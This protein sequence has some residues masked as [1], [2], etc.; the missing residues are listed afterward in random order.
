MTRGGETLRRASVF[1][2]LGAWLHIWVPPRDVEVPPVPWRK[3]AVGTG[4]AV[5]VLG[6][7]L[8]LLVPRIDHGKAT[9]AAADRRSTAAAQARN[10]ARVAREQAAHHGSAVALRP[11]AGA[12]AQERDAARARLVAGLEAD[13]LADARARSARGEMRQVEGPATCRPG[14]GQ[15]AGVMNCFVVATHIKKTSRTTAGVIGYPFRAVIDYKRF[16][17]NWCKV[18]GIPGEMSIPDPRQL[19][20]LPQAC[21]APGSL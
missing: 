17:Y 12:S 19:V 3:L 13:V 8:A 21:K 14:A 1:E 18:E 20:Q 2:I 11:A 9:R 6:I 16:T 7:A 10:R 4:I 5:V 15:P